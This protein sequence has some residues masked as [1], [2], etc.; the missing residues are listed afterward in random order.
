MQLGLTSFTQN[1][2]Q[3]FGKNLW[4]DFSEVTVPFSNIN[5]FKVVWTDGFIG[6][7]GTRQEG[8]IGQGLFRLGGGRALE[9][10]YND[11]FLIV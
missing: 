2:K 1:R 4:V 8:E 9:N 5:A 6:G 11:S 3:K 7:R 10:S